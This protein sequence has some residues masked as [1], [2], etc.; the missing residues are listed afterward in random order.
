MVFSLALTHKNQHLFLYQYLYSNKKPTQN[1]HH[2]IINNVCNRDV[3]FF[4]F[5]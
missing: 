5:Y 3:D 4:I 1:H 2:I